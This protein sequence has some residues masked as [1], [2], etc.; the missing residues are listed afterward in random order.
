MAH[1][2]PRQDA[3]AQAR[4]NATQHGLTPEQF[5]IR[6]ENAPEDQRWLQAIVVGTDGKRMF[7]VQPS[8][9]FRDIIGENA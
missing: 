4:R 2:R 5:S 8:T 6:I 7:N 3:I 1:V 9:W